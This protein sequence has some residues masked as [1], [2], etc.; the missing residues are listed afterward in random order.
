MH[1]DRLER[2]YLIAVSVMLGIFFAALVAGALVFGVRLP[3]TAEFVNPLALNE[4]E[5][6]SPGL[7]DMGEG[8]YEAYFLAAMWRFQLGT[9]E[10]D[11]TG[12]EVMRVPV[13]SRVTFNITSRDI[14]HGMIIEGMNV[15][16]QLLPG[17]VARQAVTFNRT[18][19][20]HVQC[21]EYCGRDHA[22]MFFTI[23]VEEPA[24]AAA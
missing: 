8:Q 7:R 20:F 24:E 15:N 3:S 23:I 21:H 22:N 9:G 1:M 4:T 13:G 11:E 5:F 10:F 16:L 6:A 14:S 19:E 2:N 12:H 17:H 18:G